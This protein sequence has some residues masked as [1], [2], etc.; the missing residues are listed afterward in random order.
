ML[1]SRVTLDAESREKPAGQAHAWA[2][3]HLVAGS[4]AA[5]SVLLLLAATYLG[6]RGLR[7]FDS[8]LVGYAV[9]IGSLTFGAVYR[10]I[11]WIAS[12]PTRRYLTQARH[13]LSSRRML[14][15]QVPRQIVSYLVLQTF[16]ARRARPRWLA[17][18]AIFWGVILATV[19]TFPLVLGWV[20]FRAIAGPGHRYQMYALGF[21]TV[22]FGA[23]SWFGWIVFH[24][25]DLAAALVLAGCGYFVWRRFHDREATTGQR[26]GYDF[27][28]LVA[29]IAI[30][31]TGLLLTASSLWLQ[32][33][34]YDFLVIAHIV[35]VVL[36][37]A[38]IPFSKFFHV[39][40]RPAYVGVDLFKRVSLEREGVFACRRCGEPLEAVGFVRNLEETMNDL[41]LEFAQWS[42]TCP[43]CK[44]LRRGEEFLRQVKKGF[45]A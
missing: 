39:F 42:E 5:G 1:D 12:P 4:I 35:T 38:Y 18:Q 2:R 41:N 24:G 16:I 31:A 21:E 9:G 30:S 7:N 32:G 26:F 27:I 40:Q 34:G 19:I 43:R 36:S 28:P 14:V 17:H 25:L 22:T 3:V 10:S 29:L 13:A 44:R 45:V 15:R 23:L 37:L 6:S 20:N 8:A 33:S 11:L